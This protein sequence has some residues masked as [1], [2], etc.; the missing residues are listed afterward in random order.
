MN[1]TRFEIIYSYKVQWY[2][3]FILLFP[4]RWKIWKVLECFLIN[5]SFLITYL[6]WYDVLMLQWMILDEMFFSRIL[7]FSSC[8][9]ITD[10]GMFWEK[11]RKGQNWFDICS[12]KSGLPPESHI[13]EK[14]PKILSES[15]REVLQLKIIQ[16]TISILLHPPR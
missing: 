16:F 7:H 2:A 6:A 4:T 1:A 15:F 11:L 12:L 10:L 5:C 9:K 8:M 3:L 14:I 13:V